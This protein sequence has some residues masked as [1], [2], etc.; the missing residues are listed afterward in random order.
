MEFQEVVSYALSFICW[1]YLVV[2][3]EQEEVL[4]YA[5]N[6][7]PCYHIHLLCVY[8]ITLQLQRMCTT[9]PALNTKQIP[10]L[11]HME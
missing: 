6:E 10:G 9:T 11:F 3:C 2:K 7:A 5:W 1:E 8:P 4:L